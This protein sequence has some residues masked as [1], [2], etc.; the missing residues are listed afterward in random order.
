M[1][2]DGQNTQGGLGDLDMLEME[3]LF[4]TGTA[5]VAPLASGRTAGMAKFMDVPL[6][7]TLEVASAEVTLGELANARA[8]DVLPLDKVV[9]EAL[10]VKVNG[11]LFAKAEVVMVNGNYGLKFVSTGQTDAQGMAGAGEP[12]DG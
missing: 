7:V 2:N 8:G 4:A 6:T 5:G 1:I 11:V 12:V 3:D 9:G 10:D